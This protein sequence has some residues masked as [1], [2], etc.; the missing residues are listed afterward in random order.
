MVK[1][2]SKLIILLFAWLTF[3]AHSE[4]HAYLDSVREYLKNLKH[5]TAEFVQIDQKGNEQKGKFFLSRPGKMRWEYN[6]PNEILVVMDGDKI[7]Y[8][9]K[10]LDQGSNYMNKKGLTSLFAE[11]DIFLSKE[12]KIEEFRENDD[13]LKVVFTL[14]DQPTKLS[15]IFDKNPLKILGFIVEE[16]SGNKIAIELTNLETHF[17]MDQKIFQYT[18]NLAPK[19]QR[20]K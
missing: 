20:K 16:E 2:A 10:E 15:V 8:Y 19:R 13:S 3:F 7:Y 11:E 5:V 4:E 17:S 6:A 12:I 18:Q 1:F 14:K 9:D